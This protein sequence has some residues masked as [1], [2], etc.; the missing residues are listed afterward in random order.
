MVARLY[1]MR[2]G[3]TACEAQE[4]FEPAVGAPLTAEGADYVVARADELPAKVAAVYGGNG[5]AERQTAELVARKLGVKARTDPDLHEL[6]Y[7]LWQGLTYAE[8]R[9]R[10]PRAYRQWREEPS[11][12]RPPGGETLAEAQ[13]RV[14]AALRE[15]ARRHPGGSAVL[16]LGPV[17]LALAKRALGGG[18][19]KRFWDQVASSEPVGRY[20]V[21]D[22]Q[23]A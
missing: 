10:Q 1:L 5:Q 6:D 17:A 16:V 12:A 23:P 2:T 15:I 14:G 8:I 11:L 9:R 18:A 19:A 21:D 13:A 4:R 7:G 22:E 20:E 3:R